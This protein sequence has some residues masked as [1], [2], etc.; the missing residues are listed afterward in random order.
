VSNIRET[1]TTSTRKADAKEK[2]STVTTTTTKTTVTKH[3]K[4]GDGKHVC[5]FGGPYGAWLLTL[6]LPALVVAVNIACTKVSECKTAV[7][8][9]IV[10]LLLAVFVE[11]C[12]VVQQSCSVNHVPHI[13]KLLSDYYDLKAVIYFGGWF[14][15]QALLAALPVGRVKDGQPLSSGKRLKYRCNGSGL[16]MLLVTKCFFDWLKNTFIYTYLNVKGIIFY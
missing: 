15:A 14:V 13:P 8:K 9:L 11:R 16:V 4:K 10:K 6:L 3:E 2:V 5:E 7:I 12:C 1:L